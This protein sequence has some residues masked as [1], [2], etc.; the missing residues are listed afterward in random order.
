MADEIISTYQQML[1]ANEA[2]AKQQ[3]EL[4][5]AQTDQAIN[6]INQNID[7]TKKDYDAQQK[8]TYANYKKEIDTY[9]ANGEQI[10]SSGLAGSG[11]QESSKVNAFN[12]WQ[13]NMQTAKVQLDR[14]MVEYNN[15]ITQ[16][17]LNNN[18]QLASIAYNALQ[19]KMQ[20]SLQM[21]T[22]QQQ[23]AKQANA[24]KTKDTTDKGNPLDDDVGKFDNGNNYGTEKKASAKAQ[25]RA[26]NNSVG[27]V[28]L[29]NTVMTK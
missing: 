17:K 11:Y 20:L 28:K 9:G 25:D 8:A 27:K 12:T 5:Q 22:Y 3:A 21:A 2:Y 7:N 4:Q 6:E 19:T 16:A 13:N 24:Y 1:Q 14:A 26:T 18:V 10:V 15:Q 23:L 29:Y